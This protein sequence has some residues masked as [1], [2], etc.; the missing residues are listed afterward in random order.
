MTNFLLKRGIRDEKNKEIKEQTYIHTDRQIYR[1]RKR[2]TE[3]ER[4]RKKEKLMF[5]VFP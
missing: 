2:E 4:E 1:E 5:S 3:G